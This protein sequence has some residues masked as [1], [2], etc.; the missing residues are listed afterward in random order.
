MSNK[1][2]KKRKLSYSQHVV[3][4]IDILGFRELVDKRSP[5]FISRAIRDVRDITV[6]D[7]L[8]IKRDKENYVNFSDL[9]VHTIPI[10][11][12][13]KENKPRSI[14]SGELRY[15]ALV[16]AVLIDKGLLLRG[17]VTFGDME[18]SY[19]VLFGPGLISAYELERDH[20]QYPRIIVDKRLIASL[21][22]NSLLRR[23]SYEREMRLL[24][25]CIR[26]D[27]DGLVFIDYLG[28]MRG[29][30]KSDL[31]SYHNLVETHKKLIEKNLI[32]FEGNRRVLSKYLWLRKYHNAV[33]RA[34][35][36][37]DKQSNYYINMPEMS[38]EIRTLTPKPH[39]H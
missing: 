13:T 28:F 10:L 5:N 33:I 15:L 39:Q 17:A 2:K 3:T 24:S 27:D 25:N 30:L 20:A 32:K 26:L 34:K 11:S 8:A 35:L 22:N 23:Y 21:R 7:A 29:A 38:L 1:R 36:G 37:R 19:G 9:I 16:Q 4:Y 6:P 31:L 18:R 12:E 14:V